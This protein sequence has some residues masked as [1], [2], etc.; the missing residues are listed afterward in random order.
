[1][2]ARKLSRQKNPPSVEVRIPATIGQ[3]WND[4]LCNS[5]EECK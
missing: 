5:M 3:D 4:V 2:L 1:M